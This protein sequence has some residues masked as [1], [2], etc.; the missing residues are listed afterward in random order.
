MT[1]TIPPDISSGVAA[2]DQLHFEFFEALGELSSTS[3][4]DFAAG[5]RAFVRQAE[6]SFATEEDWM[7]MMDFPILKD[8]REQHAR[9]LSALHH[10]Y[11]RIMTGDIKKGRE[12]VDKLLPQW[13]SFHILTMDKALASAMQMAGMHIIPPAYMQPVSYAA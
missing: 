2:M 13:F 11:S 3:D 8:H 10:V 9:V 4:T 1:H 7:E 12:V 6:H 5:Y